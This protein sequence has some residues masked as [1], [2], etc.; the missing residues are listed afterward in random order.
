M[1]AAQTARNGTHR[2]RFSE[3]ALTELERYSWPGNF[4]ELSGVLETAVSRANANRA[5]IVLLEH[6]ASLIREPGLNHQEAWRRRTILERIAGFELSEVAAALRL[7]GGKKDQAREILQYPS[8]HT[9]RRRLDVI[10]RKHPKVWADF[11]E[12]IQY[13]GNLD[14]DQMT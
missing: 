10:Q 11:P 1:L 8:R 13:Y 12:L 2:L 3:E 7:T 6:L 9:M 14:A 5:R 4:R